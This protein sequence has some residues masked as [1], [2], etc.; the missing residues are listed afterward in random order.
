MM[1]LLSELDW[2]VSNL[3]LQYDKAFESGREDPVRPQQ[4]ATGAKAGVRADVRH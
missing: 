3:V 1:R 4:T 2:F